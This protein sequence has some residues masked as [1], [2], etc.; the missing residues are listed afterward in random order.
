MKLT[1][2]VRYSLL[3]VVYLA[4][5]NQVKSLKCIA[6]KYDLSIQYLEQLAN[7]LRK[8]G[9][10]KSV[11]GPKGGYYLE[12]TPKD[13]TVSEIFRV[14]EGPIQVLESDEK[15][16]PETRELYQRM[17]RA[18]NLVVKETTIQDLMDHKSD[19]VVEEGYMFYI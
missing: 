5:Q 11:R 18:L 13:I 3:I 10:I 6:E 14:F 17:T 4:E 9:L 8:S 19:S 7:A 1:T 12:R 16:P 2:Q 15:E